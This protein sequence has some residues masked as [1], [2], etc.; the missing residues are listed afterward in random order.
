MS[1]EI[2]EACFACAAPYQIVEAI[3]I[4]QEL[5]LEADLYVFATFPNHAQIA[6][7]LEKFH[8]FSNIYAINTEKI[9]RHTWIKALQNFL[10]PNHVATKFMP[11]HVAYRYYYSTSR[12][13]LRATQL[14][15]LWDRNP[16]MKRVMFEDGLGSYSKRGGLMRTTKL[17][18][19]AEHMLG[20][21]LE[22][23][24][25]MLFMSYLP[26][27]MELPAPFNVCPVEQMPRIKMNEYNR[28][29]IRDIFSLDDSAMIT[30]RGI[31]FD[32]P[33]RGDPYIDYFTQDQLDILDSCYELVR[34]YAGDDLICKPHPK[35][36]ERTKAN[37]KIYP[38]QEIPM[39]IMYAEIDNLDEL[40][41]ISL[42][43]SA[44]FTPKIVFDAEPY[45]ICIYKILE[46]ERIFDRFNG[47]Y[48]K[49][50]NEYREKERVS[51]PSTMVEMEQILE[52]IY[53]ISVEGNQ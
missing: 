37:I 50:R 32:L 21:N 12:S 51:A 19:I 47:I 24:E 2:R 1:Y 49:F 18:S 53:G 3:G 25:S 38:H 27:L 43:S 41:L 14:K 26:D 42:V 6:E 31:I 34:K 33:R 4:V 7:R 16:E 5:G 44:V 28:L 20:W 17:R 9:G 23:P 30:D 36:T 52:K 40:V 11:Q 13:S 22:R 45:V 35:S 10:L 46:D 48:E 39:E 8:V 29:L 15:V